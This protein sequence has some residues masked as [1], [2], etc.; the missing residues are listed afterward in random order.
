MSNDKLTH[1]IDL[2]LGGWPDESIEHSSDYVKVKK[3][4]FLQLRL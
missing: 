2:N 4:G 3:N 1:R